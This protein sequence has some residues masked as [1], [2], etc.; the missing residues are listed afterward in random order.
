MTNNLEKQ[1]NSEE[2]TIEEYLQNKWF[3]IDEALEYLKNKRKYDISKS[4]F[5]RHSKNV[6]LNKEIGSLGKPST[7]KEERNKGAGNVHTL[8]NGAF[9]E[10]LI[11]NEHLYNQNEIKSLKL[12]EKFDEYDI[13]DWKKNLK[14]DL[15]SLL[16]PYFNTYERDKPYILSEIIEYVSDS[17]GNYYYSLKGQNKILIRKN[18]DLEDQVKHLTGQ[19]YGILDSYQQLDYARAEIT[20]QIKIMEKNIIKEIK[21]NMDGVQ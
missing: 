9:V 2:I 4:T 6:N 18:L 15:D 14:N 3:T 5:Y 11:P 17:I 7:K 12:I 10:A 21:E 13:K 8:Y 19:K 1:L 20:D 16:T